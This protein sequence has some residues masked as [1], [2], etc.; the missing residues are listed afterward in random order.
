M[1]H[2]VTVTANTGPARPLTAFVVLNATQIL[3]NPDLKT[4]RVRINDGSIRDF[5]LNAATTVTCSISAGNYSFVV[6]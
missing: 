3:F 2:Q 5:D 6:S 1:P 4:L